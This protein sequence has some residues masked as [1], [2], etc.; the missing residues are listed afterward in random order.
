MVDVGGLIQQDFDKD[1]HILLG[2][3]ME[4]SIGMSV[5]LGRFLAIWK[6]ALK[7]DELIDQYWPIAKSVHSSFSPIKLLEPRNELKNRL[8]AWCRMQGK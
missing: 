5:L 4:S 6:T 1:G 7:A 2:D 8:T 3:Q